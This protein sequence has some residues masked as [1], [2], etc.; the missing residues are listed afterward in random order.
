MQGLRIDRT[1]LRGAPVLRVAGQ[2]DPLTSGFLL[3][4][5][6]LLAGG[7]RRIGLDLSGVDS[8]DAG[9]VVVLA[10]LQHRLMQEGR[11]LDILEASLNV[12][13]V[14]AGLGLASLLFQP[15]GAEG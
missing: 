10:S 14:F 8:I 3:E 12:R 9:S 1:H 15:E 4:K 6:E 7:P 5:L 2:I 11:H 13:Q